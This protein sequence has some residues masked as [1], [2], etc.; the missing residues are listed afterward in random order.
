MLADV[1]LA[2]NSAGSFFCKE[3]IYSELKPTSRGLVG[4]WPGSMPHHPPPPQITPQS[5]FAYVREMRAAEQKPGV[6]AKQFGI[7]AL[8]E[9]EKALIELGVGRAM[10]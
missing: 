4:G 5:S 2:N 6:I 10:P 3:P 8:G 7:A 1:A 9:A